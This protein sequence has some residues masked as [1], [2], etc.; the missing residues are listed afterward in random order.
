MR[1]FIYVALVFSSHHVSIGLAKVVTGCTALVCIVSVPPR[2]TDIW[3]ARTTVNNLCGDNE[4]PTVSL[5]HVLTLR[6]VGHSVLGYI[7]NNKQSARAIGGIF[8]S[9][10]IRTPAATFPLQTEVPLQSLFI[11]L[12]YTRRMNPSNLTILLHPR[13]PTFFAFHTSIGRYTPLSFRPD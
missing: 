11:M 5:N 4:S 7:Y 2:L 3:L 9:D 13:P 8:A 12:S 10:T 6:F 1:S